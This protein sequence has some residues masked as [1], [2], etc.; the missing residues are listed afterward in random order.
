ML[1][2]FLDY[3]ELYAY[4]DMFLTI[5][6]RLIPCARTASIFNISFKTFQTKEN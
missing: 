3:S 2:I 5:A 1:T 4:I 6:S